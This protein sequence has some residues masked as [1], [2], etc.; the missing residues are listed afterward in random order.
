[1]EYHVT[2]VSDGKGITADS[3]LNGYSTDTDTSVYLRSLAIDRKVSKMLRLLD[4][5]KQ[6]AKVI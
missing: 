6:A 3:Q 2:V 4:E 5:H 1:M